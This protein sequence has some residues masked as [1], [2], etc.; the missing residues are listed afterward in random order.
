MAKAKNDIFDHMEWR[1]SRGQFQFRLRSG[2]NE[3]VHASEKYKSRSV[4]FGLMDRWQDAL[5]EKVPVYECNS[6]WDRL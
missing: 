3:V 4:M 2:N 1:K 6:K 5:K